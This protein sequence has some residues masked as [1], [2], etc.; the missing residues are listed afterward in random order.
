MVDVC[1]SVIIQKGVTCVLVTKA[2]I[3]TGTDIHVE[4]VLQSQSHI[5]LPTRYTNK[6]FSVVSLL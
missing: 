5:A 3:L 2:T 1:T 4:V 6:L